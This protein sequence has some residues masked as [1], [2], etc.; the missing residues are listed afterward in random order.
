[1]VTKQ[2]FA[3][4]KKA[5]EAAGL[6]AEA[7]GDA[8]KGVV[9]SQAPAADTP[10]RKGTKVVLTLRPA[11]ERVAVPDLKGQ[12]L[13]AAQ[14][15]L[16]DLGLVAQPEGDPDKGKVAS[17]NPAAGIEVPKGSAVV[18]TLGT[19]DAAVIVPAVAGLPFADAKVELEKAGLVAAP[20]TGA[21]TVQSQEP[22]ANAAVA[23]GTPVTLTL[24]APPA[25]PTP[26]PVPS[27]T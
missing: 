18:V 9:Q 10:V 27:P 1:D 6:Q 23:R 13:A 14:K 22:A 11:L 25:P 16:D 24:A 26:E 8:D 20:D 3:E 2:S 4:A 12:T 21:G 17:Q 15:A 7:D 19:A 5:L